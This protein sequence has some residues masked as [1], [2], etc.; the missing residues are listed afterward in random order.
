MPN[1]PVEFEFRGLPVTRAAEAAAR[2]RLRALESACP[3]AQAWRVRVEALPGAAQ[4][5]HFC[6][7]VR[8]SVSGGDQL[9]THARAEDPLAAL[10]LAFNALETALARERESERH[11]AGRLL[12]AVRSRLGRRQGGAGHALP[13]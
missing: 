11:L 5:D 8:A 7:D 2:R 4:P 9:E 13:H 1:Q 3:A 10:R 6:A 12:R